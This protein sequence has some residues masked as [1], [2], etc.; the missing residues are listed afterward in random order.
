MSSSTSEFRNVLG[1]NA[2]IIPSDPA[3]AASPDGLEVGYSALM[4]ALL[5]L[6][7]SIFVSAYAVLILKKKNFLN[8]WILLYCIAT[9]ITAILFYMSAGIV[10]KLVGSAGIY[11]NAVEL[12]LVL[13]AFTNGRL[14]PN[15]MI[16]LVF[17]YVSIVSF[18]FLFAG[19]T[20]APAIFIGQGLNL[21]WMVVFIFAFIAYNQQSSRT[22]VKA[23]DPEALE[24][25]ETPFSKTAMWLL[26]ISSLIHVFSG[27]LITASP[28]N[29]LIIRIIFSLCYVLAFPG[30]AAASLSLT[31]EKEGRD[32]RLTGLQKS[33]TFLLSLCLSL[34]TVV[35]RFLLTH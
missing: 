8:Y 5:A 13:A 17:V 24:E 12:L 6:V 18:G 26:I 2:W 27:T 30:F 16:P 1:Y 19:Y 20:A 32:L 14:Q 15:W 11:H 34:G 22:G 4:V 35:L 9:L 7:F 25:R 31:G 21:D 3:F 10:T 23:T 29:T 33:L 28:N